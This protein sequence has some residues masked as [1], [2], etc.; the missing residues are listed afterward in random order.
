VRCAIEMQNSL[1][2]RSAG[3]PPEK[4]IEYRVAIHVGDVVEESD[5]NLMG[6]GVKIAARLE[7]VCET[8]GLCLS[9]AAYEQ[10]RDRL[11]EPFVDLGETTLKNIARPVRV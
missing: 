1:I 2:E 10:L 5:G 8:N 4:R 6:D 11:K 9:G 7:G 3:V